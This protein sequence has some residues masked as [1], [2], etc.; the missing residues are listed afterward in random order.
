MG[1]S[2]GERYII[3][4]LAKWVDAFHIYD[5]RC[6]ACRHI[7]CYIGRYKPEHLCYGRL[8]LCE[9]HK[10]AVKTCGRYKRL[11]IDASGRRADLGGKHRRG[12]IVLSGNDGIDT[13]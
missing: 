8:A 11:C 5:R 4:D 9:C 6:N 7:G 1:N 10:Y 12:H 13:N 3:S 2:C